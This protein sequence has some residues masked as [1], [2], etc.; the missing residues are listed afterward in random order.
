[1][2]VYVK[3]ADMYFYMSEETLPA[4]VG[5]RVYE[6]GAVQ[7]LNDAVASAKTQEEAIGLVEKRYANLISGV[8]RASSGRVSDPILAE[9]RDIAVK[10][11]L[12]AFV[13]KGIKA[14][15]AKKRPEYA[16]LVKEYAAREST[17]AQAR[18]NVN[19][20][21]D[22]GDVDIDLDDMDDEEDEKEDL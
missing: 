1:M 10:K 3:K 21:D 7:I 2:Q 18:E 17:I 14:A 4:H 16:E 20:V 19:R 13:K 9:A 12:A 6:Y 11:I 22:L 8:L 15:E 5:R